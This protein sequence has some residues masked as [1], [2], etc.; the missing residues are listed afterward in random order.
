MNLPN[1]LT[2]A[3]LMMLPFFMTFTY[4]DNVVTRI[5]ALI[6]FVAAG[7][8][9][10]VDGYLARK[11]NLVTSLGVFL[12]PLADKLL[13]TAALISFVAL[14]QSHIP[15]WMVVLVVGREFLVTGLR[16]LAASRGIIMAADEG[17]KLKTS[18]QTTAIVV[19]LIS[20]IV[21]SLFEKSGGLLRVSELYATGWRHV[22]AQM[23]LWTPYGLTLMATV[24]SLWSGLNYLRKHG[25]LLSENMT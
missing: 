4:V 7:V 17:G 12:D 1:K 19:T 15:A 10:L 16:M 23:I 22:S 25:S 6:I 20:L 11:Y 13:V 5:V 18:I 9:D 8:T 21:D 24:L 14:P 2:M 3:R